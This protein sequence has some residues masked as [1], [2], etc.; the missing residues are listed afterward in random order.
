MA[1]GQLLAGKIRQTVAADQTAVAGPVLFTENNF[2][3]AQ[4]AVQRSREIW[5][6]LKMVQNECLLKK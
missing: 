2:L 3:A 5:G 4:G 1:G 6:V